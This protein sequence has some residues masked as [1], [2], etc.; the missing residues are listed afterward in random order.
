ML[1]Q[2]P[3]KNPEARSNTA[4]KL[5]STRADVRVITRDCKPDASSRTVTRQLDEVDARPFQ[6]R[7]SHF[8]IDDGVQFFAKQLLEARTT[9]ARTAM[10]AI[11]RT[12]LAHVL[13]LG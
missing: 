2:A 10:L 7:I 13:D 5:A 3:P 9:N 1:A 11:A 6:T 12:V 8:T 4:S